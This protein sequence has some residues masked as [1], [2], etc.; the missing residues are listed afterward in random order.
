V[1]SYS[2][3]GGYQCFIG[4]CCLHLQDKSDL[5]MY[6]LGYIDKLQC[7][8]EGREGGKEVYNDLGQLEWCRGNVM[9]K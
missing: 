7:M 3:I 1:T 6:V 4:T 8:S 2:L 5:G 9:I